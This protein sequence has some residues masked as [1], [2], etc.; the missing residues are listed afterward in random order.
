MPIVHDVP[1]KDRP[2]TWIWMLTFTWRCDDKAADI[3]N[4]A[5]IRKIWDGYANVLGGPLRDAFIA[6]PD[7][8]TLWCDRIGQWPTVAWDDHHG[9]VTLAGDAAHPMTFRK[10][11][12]SF[13][14]Y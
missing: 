11:L 1:N 4:Q 3:T 9:R 8:S 13:V 6:A 14:I 2:E 12:T 5:E 7:R 10:T